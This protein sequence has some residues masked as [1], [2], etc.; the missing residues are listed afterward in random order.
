MTT[1]DETP[2]PSTGPEHTPVSLRTAM[3]TPEMLRADR[4]LLVG[5]ALLGTV[6]AGPLGI[7]VIIAAMVAM[8]RLAK[9]RKLVRPWSITL[10][11]ILALLDASPNFFG[12][13]LDLFFGHDT[14]IGSSLMTGWG[15]IAEGSNYIGY[16]SKPLGGIANPA[17]KTIEVWG[18]LVMYPLRMA[19][20]WGLLRM[21]RWGLQAMIYTA[22]LQM[23]FW[24]G[25][26][27]LYSIQFHDEAGASLLGPTGFWMISLPMSS[28]FVSLP[29][30]LG[31]DRRRLSD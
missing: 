30:L 22:F 20:A 12:W 15:K 25:Y 10:V 26:V 7:P 18:V 11:A 13:G 6:I 19:A 4:I 14:P 3:D 9:D 16:N 21:K 24:I 8:N 17:V 23:A 31:I 5:V 1:L 27:T 28:C 2:K 29:L